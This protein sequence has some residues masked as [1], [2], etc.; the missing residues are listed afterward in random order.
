[1]LPKSVILSFKKR[2]RQATTFKKNSCDACRH[3]GVLRGTG[4][5]FMAGVGSFSNRCAR[6]EVQL[7]VMTEKEPDGWTEGLTLEDWMRGGQTPDS[8]GNAWLLDDGDCEPSQQE[9]DV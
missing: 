4:P 7:A 3:E 8:S 6:L 2:R 9:G 1:M 5:D